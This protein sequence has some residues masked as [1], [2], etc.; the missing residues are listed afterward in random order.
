[1][2]VATRPCRGNHGLHH[3]RAPLSWLILQSALNPLALPRITLSE[4]SRQ[5]VFQ[6]MVHIGSEGFYRSVVYDMLRARDAGPVLYFERDLRACSKP[7]HGSAP[8]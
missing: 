8:R 4:G 5:G 3:G 7:A 1:M 6:G 2:A